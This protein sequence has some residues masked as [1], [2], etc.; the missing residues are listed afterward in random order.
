MKIFT[1]EEMAKLTAHEM[2]ALADQGM[3][4]TD[5]QAEIVRRAREPDVRIADMEA[6]IARLKAGPT[7][8]ELDTARSEGYEEG[9]SEGQGDAKG[10]H[11]DLWSMLLSHLK[12]HDCE[13]VSDDGQGHNAYQVMDAVFEREANIRADG[14]RLAEEENARLR[15]ALQPFADVADMPEYKLIPVNDDLW[16]CALRLS[17]YRRAREQLKAAAS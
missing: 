10:A 15:A 16:V 6:E 14:K 11:A 5:E 3:V 9:Y 12:K 17:A 4:L 8:D 2:A 7:E 13:P 1:P